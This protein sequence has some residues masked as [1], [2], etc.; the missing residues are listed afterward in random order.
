MKLFYTILSF[1]TVLSLNAQAPTGFNVTD[2]ANEPNSFD[3]S[4]EFDATAAGPVE[5]LNGNIGIFV[6][7][8]YTGATITVVNGGSW[9]LNQ[10]IDATAVNGICGT[11]GNLRVMVFANTGNADNLGDVTAGVAEDLFG[12]QLTGSTTPMTDDIQLFDPAGGDALSACLAAAGIDNVLSIDPDGAAGAAPTTGFSAIGAGTLGGAFALPVEI[13]SFDVIKRN[14]SS[15]ELLWNTESE[16]NASH[17]EIERAYDG[18]NFEYLGTVQ[19]TGESSSTVSYD[20][21]DRTIQLS[22]NKTIVYYRLK[23]VDNDASFEYSEIKNV[24]FAGDDVEVVV[25][26]NPTADYVTI[27]VGLEITGVTIFDIDGKILRDNLPYDGKVDLTSL[28]TG[29][30]N[31][32]V[33]TQGGDFLKPVIKID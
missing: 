23:A 17:F 33:H 3:V 2:V 8:Q 28:N 9:V 26:P 13:S 20:F 12:I 14:E 21:L 11:T 30:Y 29:M 4:V 1:I 19:A 27:S 6:P 25:H 10:T 22:G 16:Q 32:I 5:A 7:D 31:I 15:A 18:I 24:D